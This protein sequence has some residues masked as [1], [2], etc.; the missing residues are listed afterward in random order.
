[1]FSFFTDAN[2]ND[3]MS[4]EGIFK[5]LQDLMLAPDSRL[6]LILAWKMRAATQCE[7]SRDEFLN[8]LL[9][10]GYAIH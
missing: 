7:F 2:E 1:M 10:L 3:K 6:V 4:A 9:E 8:G 5:L